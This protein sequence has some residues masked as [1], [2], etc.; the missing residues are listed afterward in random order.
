VRALVRTA[1]KP[2]LGPPVP[3]A[4]QRAWLE[5]LAT[6]AGPAGART[7]CGGRPAE[8]H[9]SGSGSVLLLHGGAFV[10][11]SPRTHRV[12]AAGLAASSGA[13]VVVPDYRR[14]PESPWPAAVDD[15]V[16]AYDELAAAGPVAVVGDSAGGSLALLLARRRPPVALGLV[17][18]VA[19]L[20]GATSAAYRGHDALLR[21]DWLQA[22]AAAWVGGADARELSALHA[23]L[24]GLPPVLV[25]VGEHERLRPEAELLVQRIVAAGGAAELVVL[26][27][28]WHDAHVFAHLVPQAAQATAALG[29]WLRTHLGG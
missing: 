23:D 1:L 11:S 13:Q 17:S 14:A 18:P 27:G 4:A 15:A 21:Q 7:T 5:L 24:S 26:P 6:G 28:M 25:H 29:Q 2:V 22:G 19:D 8:R 12:L 20:T 10:T 9:G 3:L 16:A